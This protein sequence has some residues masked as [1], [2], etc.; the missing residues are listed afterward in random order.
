MLFW[1][2]VCGPGTGFAETL[3]IATFN[4]EL[5]RKG[6]G[7]MLRD[8]LKGDPQAE[9]VAGVIAA[10]APDVVLLNGI[11]FDHDLLALSALSDLIAAKGHDMPHRFA[12]RPNSGWA[13]GLD[14]DGDGRLGGPGDAHGWGRFAGDGGMA[15]LSRHPIGAVRDLSDLVWSAQDWATL[16]EVKGEVFPSKE[17][18]TIQRLSSVAH[19]VVPIEVDGRRL[20]LMAF[21]AAPPV[22]D[23]PEDRNGKRN[24]DEIT[25]W[26]H[27]LD[28]KPGSAPGG[29]FAIIGDANLD[30]VDGDGIKAAITGLLGDPR[31]Q[32]PKPASEG[33]QAAADEAHRGNPALDTVDWPGEEPG[34]PGNLR[35]DY[36]LPSADLEVVGAG[37]YWPAPGQSGEEMARMASR[38]RLVWVDV[39]W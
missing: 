31:L 27:F 36:V 38:H 29:S 3:R 1:A 20:D 24:H 15:V 33:G 9:A 21:H 35:V 25:L 2:A 10:V 11:D 12:T 23:G 7:L 37:V 30:P 26:R 39:R 5:S 17:A 8:I 6:P 32:D 34:D 19:W 18:M 14:L 16:P 22:F 28:G 4:A 13:T